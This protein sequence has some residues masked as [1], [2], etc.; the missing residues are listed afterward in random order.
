M[1]FLNLILKKVKAS[2]PTCAVSASQP[3]I[4]PNTAHVDL[5]LKNISDNGKYR[6]SRLT[7]VI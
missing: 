3:H 1:T 6:Y 4:D 7:D 2:K 5:P